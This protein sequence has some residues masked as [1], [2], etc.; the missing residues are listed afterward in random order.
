MKK[1]VIIR[2]SAIQAILR[3]SSWGYIWTP[4]TSQIHLELMLKE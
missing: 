1:P 2:I 3:S 4:D